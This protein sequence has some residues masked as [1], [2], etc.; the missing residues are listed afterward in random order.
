MNDT[1]V[2]SNGG[3]VCRQPSNSLP[4]YYLACKANLLRRSFNIPISDISGPLQY[5]PIPSSHDPISC[6]CSSPTLGASRPGEGGKGTC[7][8]RRQRKAQAREKTEKDEMATTKD[9]QRTYAPFPPKPKGEAYIQLVTSRATDSLMSGI[10]NSSPV[11]S[12]P[13][14]M[15]NKG[16]PNIVHTTNVT[17]VV[18]SLVNLDARLGRMRR[19]RC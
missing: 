13:C 5:P 16:S 6:V 14:S 17:S 15:R 11:Y 3:S 1:V 2:F 10:R 8:S 12:S 7:V 18:G 9:P 4:W 19:R